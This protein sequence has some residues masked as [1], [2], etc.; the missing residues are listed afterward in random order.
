MKNI[1]THWDI[2]WKQLTEKNKIL[3]FC[4]DLKFPVISSKPIKIVGASAHQSA[5]YFA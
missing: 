1:Y 4:Y 5:Y 2:Y 3:I